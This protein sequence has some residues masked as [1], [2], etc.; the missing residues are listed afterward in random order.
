MVFADERSTVS[1]FHVNAG[2]FGHLKA[3]L[4]AATVL[5]FLRYAGV[6]KW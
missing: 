3:V 5:D 6:A 2:E 4:L 1:G